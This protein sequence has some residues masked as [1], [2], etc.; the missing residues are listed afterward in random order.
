LQA[1]TARLI[2]IEWFRYLDSHVIL[3]KEYVQG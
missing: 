3:G 2:E 1:H